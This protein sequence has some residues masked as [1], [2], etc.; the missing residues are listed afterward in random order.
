MAD[1]I[2]ASV[3]VR[4]RFAADTADV[5]VVRGFSLGGGGISLSGGGIA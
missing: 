5:G 3:G 2:S 4:P 1:S